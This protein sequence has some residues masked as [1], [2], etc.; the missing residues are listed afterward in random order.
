MSLW[1]EV[2]VPNNSEG[3]LADDDSALVTSDDNPLQVDA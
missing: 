1:V 3:L 2:R